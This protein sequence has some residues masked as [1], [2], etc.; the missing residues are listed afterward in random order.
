MLRDEENLPFDLATQVVEFTGCSLFLTGKAGTGK[1]TFLKFI[2]EHTQKNTVVVAPT[3]VAAINAGGVTIHSFFQ[4]P[5]VPYLPGDSLFGQHEYSVNRSALLKGIR[6]NKEKLD[7]I[8]SLELLIVDEVSMLRADML[9]AMDEILRYFR[10]KQH[11]PFGGVQILFIGDL[12]QLPPVVAEQEWE[13][14]KSVY[15]SPFFFSSRVVQ[16]YPPLHIELKKI[17]R[18]KEESF[19]HLLNQIRNNRMQERDF[20]L[21]NDRFHPGLM[22]AGAG[23]I[24][25]CSHNA[26]A[27][28]INRMELEK[29]E[30]PVYSYEGAIRGDFSERN[31]PTE[32]TLLLKIGAQVMFIRND[33]D[34]QKRYF[35][36]KLATVV[37]LGTEKIT[38]KFESEDVLLELEKEVW[39]NIKYVYNANTDRVEEEELGS[40]TQYPVRL[41]WAITIHKSQGLTFDRVV[42]DAG[43]SFAAGQVYVALSRCRTLDGISLLSGIKPASLQIDERIIL[44]SEGEHA[45]DEITA[46]IEK[47]KPVYAAQLF[48]R[49][50]D[51][52]RLLH[53]F[54]HLESVTLAKKL[55]GKEMLSGVV[56][57]LVVQMTKLSDYAERFRIQLEI[58]L[59]DKPLNDDLLQDR[60]VKAKVYFAG[61]IHREVILPIQEMQKFLNGK[62]LVKQYIKQIQLLEEQCWKKLQQVQSITFGT[63]TFDV[64]RIGK[65]PVVVAASIRK[66]K[67]EKKP[68]GSSSL[69]TLV[70][71]QQGL[72]PE[73]IAR[74][75]GFTLATI[76]NHLV[77]YI[78]NGEVKIDDFVSE[79]LLQ[80]IREAA[81][82]TDFRQL[83]PIKQIMGDEV[84]YSQIRFALKYFESTGQVS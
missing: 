72:K 68:K 29:L 36:G 23:S 20:E 53:E 3:G 5:F 84:T 18:Q 76:E 75:R 57:G 80:K 74:K 37:D 79:A 55:P 22:H 58:I 31:L 70:L 16:Q 61:S 30:G 73:E 12:F 44:F 2:R 10:Y 41:A 65:T 48:L 25:L 56:A 33:S 49:T 27:D 51:M 83:S 82:Q 8:R 59:Q 60:V 26:M 7:I 21:L 46:I 35:N 40:F 67:K 9:D 66:E 50:F 38:V 34:P 45:V 47:E 19:I 15:E 32:H 6:F 62:P 71:Y 11:T 4:L 28:R 24:T 39:S 64:P 69:D 14:M 13:R 78:G 52:T 43:S 1:T 63:Y 77:N 42:I 54:E 17:Y 81:K